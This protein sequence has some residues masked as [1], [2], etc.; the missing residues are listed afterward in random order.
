MAD[1]L[2]FEDNFAAGLTR[3]QVFGRGASGIID[4]GDPTRGRVLTLIPDGDEVYALI[5]RSDRWGGVRLEGE[6]LF[7][8]DEDSY[9]GVIYNFR[10]RGERTDFGV[11]YIKGNDSYLQVN[12]HRDLNVG[13]TLY[14][15]Y[16]VPL[17]GDA[18]IRKGQWQRFAVEVVGRVCHFYVGNL[19]VPQLT[20]PGFEFDSGAI[21]LQPRSVGGDVWVDNL[22]VMAIERLSYVGLPKP[23]VQYDTGTLLTQWQVLGPFLR[24]D[25][26]VARSPSTTGRSWRSFEVDARGAV[27][28][29]RVVDFHGPN[30]VAY[31]RTRVSRQTAGA[32]ELQVS[33]VDDLA[34]WVNGRF[35]WFIPRRDAAW[36]DFFLNPEHVGQRIPLQ[37]TTGS[38]DLVFRV[39]GGVY[40]SGGFYARVVDSQ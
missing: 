5:K 29:S 11:V 31:F 39:R 8:S 37:L 2:L 13:R 10:R 15:E 26:E 23:N 28:T 22:K 38:N 36:F 30:S 25:D 4:S 40:G 24:T 32:A 21:G 35:R 18:A 12:P 33:T 34:L 6:V 1:R 14:G 16:R 19:V 3:W 27:I 9:L 7:P 17:T 20:F